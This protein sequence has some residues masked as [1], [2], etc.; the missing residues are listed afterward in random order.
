M[1]KLTYTLTKAVPLLLT[2]ALAMSFMAYVST[3]PVFSQTPPPPEGMQSCGNQ[4]SGG[5]S[6]PCG[7]CGSGDGGGGG[8]SYNPFNN[9]GGA[10]PFDPYTGN[11]S[12]QI[13]DL[14]VFGSVGH[15]PLEF[16][17]YSNSRMSPQS[18]SNGRFGRDTVWT[19]SYQWL[20]RSGG[21]AAN[22]KPTMLLAYP[23]GSDVIFVQS[24]TDSSLWVGPG[25]RPAYLKQTGN[26]FTHIYQDGAECRFIRRTANTG[27]ALYRLESFTD[28]IG[29]VYTVGYNDLA[30][31][32]PR[33]V[34]DPAGRWLKIFYSNLGALGQASQTLAKLA[35]GAT[36]TGAWVDIPVNVTGQPASRYLVL[37]Q[38]N[39]HNNAESLPLAEIEFYDE[40]NARISG[41]PFGS[42]PCFV[43]NPAAP[44]PLQHVPA[45]ALDGD[46]STY[47]R[48]A[49]RRNCYIGIDAGS[50][51]IV[52][53]V[54]LFIPAGVVP[55]TSVAR[56]VGLSSQPATAWTVKEVLADD[57]RN[58][59]YNYSSFVDPSGIFS[60]Q[61]LTSVNYPDGTNALYDY[62]Q[63]ADYTRPLL[64]NSM[65]THESG[66]ATHI[67]YE[68][69]P[70]TS[71][72][73]LRR[74]LSGATGETIAAIRNMT[75]HSVAVDYPNGK[76][77]VQEYAASNANM[78]R[79][80]DGLGN[81]M[82]FS[83]SQSGGGFLS[84]QKDPLNRLVQYSR[85]ALG[86]LTDQTLPDG[87]RQSWQRDERGNVTA[88]TVTQT[89]GSSVTTTSVYDSRS[90]LLRRNHPDG[91]FETWT[92]NSFGQPLTHRHPNGAQESWSYSTQGLELTHTDVVGATTRSGYDSRGL[93]ASSTDALGRTTKFTR[94]IEGRITQVVH[95]DGSSRSMTYDAYGN[96]ISET[97]EAGHVTS[98]TYDEFNRR[99]TSTDPLGRTTL[100]DYGGGPASGGCGACNSGGKPVLVT[101]PNGRKIKNTYDVEW[102]ATA[103][104]V[105]YGTSEAATT[106]MLYDRVGN[107]TKIT[108]P[109]GRA[110][111]FAYDSRNRRVKA[112]FSDGAF[113]TTT[114]DGRDNVLSVTN[115]LGKSWATSYGSMNEK[116]AETDPTGRV[117]RYSY[118]IPGSAG[119]GAAT[120]TL[121]PAG[122]T[123]DVLYDAL[124]RPVT[125][126]LAGG[127]VE[128]STTRTTYDAV[129]N[130]TATTDALGQV[131]KHGYDLRDRRISTTN[132]LGLITSYA[133]SAD[134]L[135]LSTTSPDSTVERRA[136]DAAHRLVK[137]TDAASQT[138]TYGYDVMNNLVSLA[139]GRGSVTRWTYDL[140]GRQ[141]SKIYADGSQELYNYDLASQMTSTTR[142]GGEVVTQI[143]NSRGW[144]TSV[145]S[146]GGQPSPARTY[147]Y[148]AAGHLLTLATSGVSVITRS[149]DAAERLTGE[150]QKI[151]ACGDSVFNITYVHDA[152]GRLAATIYPDGSTVSHAYNLRGELSSLND[153]GT[154][155]VLS[156]KRRSDGRITGTTHRNGVTTARAYDAASRL[157][158]VG[159][160][161]PTGTLFGGESYTLDAVSRRTSRTF[162]DGRGDVFGY[163]LTSQVTAAL[164]ATTGAA[165]KANAGGWVP[166]TTWAYD[167]AGNRTNVNDAGQ[168]TRYT[169]N[170]LNQYTAING[171]SP[172]HNRNGDLLNDGSTRSFTW[173]GRSEILSVTT[174][175]AVGTTFKESFTYD[176]LQRRIS[177]TDATGTTYFIHDGWNVIGEYRRVGTTNV[178]QRRYLWGEDLS[179]SLQGAG[180]VGGLVQAVDF[181]SGN[182]GSYHY[183]YD[184]N[185]NVVE[186]TN[187]SAT[188]VASYRYDAFGRTLAKAGT[189]AD[190]NR[191]RFSTK[192]LELTSGLYYYGYRYYS[193]EMGRWPS[194][195]L[196]GE[197]G[198]INLYGM[199]GGDLVN[200]WDYLG[201][202]EYTLKPCCCV[203][204]IDI[205]LKGPLEGGKSMEDYFPQTYP[206]MFG[207]DSRQAGPWSTNSRIGVNIQITSKTSGNDANCNF[208]QDANV[209]AAISNGTP[210]DLIHD[211]EFDDLEMSGHDQSKAPFRQNV[212]GSPS[213]ADPP[214]MPRQPNSKY[215]STFTTCLRSGG[216]NLRTTC[217]YEKCCVKWRI[218]FEID[219]NGNVTSHSVENLSKNC[220]LSD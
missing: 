77:V 193:P 134:G 147:S 59:I 101:L 218:K 103:V 169:A 12:R 88:F 127:T 215:S 115:E 213:M 178:L 187:V 197:R 148:D 99:V 43:D 73:Y 65:D 4:S 3:R 37:N 125:V 155:P 72:G 194:R 11:V 165:Q 24:T 25:N 189:Y 112:T 70:G 9:C 210:D 82:T 44:D 131:T 219:G 14:K 102:R 71:L 62:I 156:Y 95:A 17:R 195:D 172:S 89:D 8:E 196:I 93:L 20:L 192:P 182:A 217:V 146:S 98:H 1:N 220:T 36:V 78:T 142:A 214:S 55:V 81:V 144:M 19:H 207:T 21:A 32:L 79:R 161:L 211:R 29:N 18:T 42:D 109:L 110:T 179:G 203:E 56:I 61:T 204:N 39:D 94:D 180:G 92:Y 136:Y 216:D 162:A 80:V 117:T 173:S 186:I 140:T 212:G 6:Q 133:Y 69:D 67:A 58:V 122:R 149:Y 100:T 175:V 10:N 108:D 85:D 47:Y 208:T 111:L 7:G 46:T 145:T 130:L 40:K 87:T 104:T 163:D 154:V 116:L 129:G 83:Y 34:T 124:W 28:D 31:S 123:Q 118:S 184:G 49:Y 176:G 2:A 53:R 107:V 26:N 22:G 135:L 5:P 185:G 164:Y 191:Y 114:Y 170:T 16:V 66:N 75:T 64:S 190:T 63:M 15:L 201:L 206:W 54:R 23:N 128:A 132:P 106:S 41:T 183:H 202:N 96:V 121:S 84:A 177:R 51:R 13:Q 151:V 52:S 167:K 200:R 68:F 157:T 166:G 126:T 33:R 60:W 91:S 138:L 159:H 90:L 97:D 199:V 168:A 205:V 174:Q 105:A 86:N 160:S 57:G 181:T 38:T 188:V 45:K 141:K 171:K 113:T 35:Y 137:V 76:S 153:G 74:E 27:G 139:D 48:Y 50:P 150:S 158:G 30:D 209:E 198:G 152:D 119:S 120:R 143:Y